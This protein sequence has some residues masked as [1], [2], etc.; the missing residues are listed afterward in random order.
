MTPVII[1]DEA[2]Y[3]NSKVLNDLKILFNFEMD[4]RDR[5]II[6]LSG[7]PTLNNTLNLS[8]HEP[9]RQR[10]V[11]NYNMDCLNKIDAKEYVLARLASAGRP[12]SFF[13]D[14]ALE[15]LLNSAQGKPR[16]INKYC[17]SAMRIAATNSEQ[18][19]STDTVMKTINDCELN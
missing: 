5:A 4:S 13:E 1:I 19:I 8:A 3:A 14:A 9:L 12:D 18:T 15:A 16:L 10:I 7:L 11:M 2:N 6:L 17:T